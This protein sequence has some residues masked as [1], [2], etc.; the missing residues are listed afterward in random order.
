MQRGR[1]NTPFTPE[2]FAAGPAKAKQRI[3]AAGLDAP[4]VSEPAHLDQLTPAHLDQLTG[5]DRRSFHA[6]QGVE[7]MRGFARRP[8]VG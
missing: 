2:E 3:A 5:D 1:N 4:Y 6:H 7:A 8:F